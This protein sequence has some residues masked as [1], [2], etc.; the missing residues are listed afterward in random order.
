M[1]AAYS[2]ME[3]PDLEMQDS[4]FLELRDR[5]GPQS[6][7]RDVDEESY[8]EDMLKRLTLVSRAI[9]IVAEDDARSRALKTGRY[10]VHVVSIDDERY[11]LKSYGG[12]KHDSK[13][14]RRL[15][16]L[17]ERDVGGLRYRK[18]FPEVRKHPHEVMDME[19]RVLENWEREGIIG[20]KV[21]GSDGEDHLL[22]EY[23][24]S[25]DYMT[26]LKQ[27]R[28][29]REMVDGL[30]DTIGS[31]RSAAFSRRDKLM[32]HN[33]MWLANF[34][35]SDCGRTVP[36]DPGV[37]FKE[38]LSFED[39]DAHVNLFFCYSLNSGLFGF[40]PDHAGLYDDILRSFIRS[41]DSWT[42][43]RMRKLNRP[44]NRFELAYLEL[45]VKLGLNRPYHMFLDT[46][47]K[48]RCRR[49]DAALEG[50]G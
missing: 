31:I 50:A 39:L 19:R 16:Y 27:G 43:E 1:D 25:S 29:S 17:L 40:N 4:A 26:L 20:P 44:T 10:Q 42:L 7:V 38:E 8:V 6:L 49:V 23:I 35:W 48:E 12:V 22:L 21:I 45:T 24:P 33:D 5:Y 3:N 18:R 30:I 28:C 14:Q 15:L 34:L 41:L 47:N 2:L 13:N 9:D 46:F 36:I 37:L 11:V 32:L